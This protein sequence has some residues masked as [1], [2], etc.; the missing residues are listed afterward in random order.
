MFQKLV[1]TFIIMMSPLI[2][3]GEML[4][5]M[6]MRI[7]KAEAILKAYRVCAESGRATDFYFQAR[8]MFDH[9]NLKNPNSCERMNRDALVLG[10][11]KENIKNFVDAIANDFPEVSSDQ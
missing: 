1:F 7:N 11:S 9:L 5:G 8:N 2:S 10:A 3:F 6:E 4:P